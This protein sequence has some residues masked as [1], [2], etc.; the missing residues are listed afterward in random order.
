MNLF[1]C[2]SRLQQIINYI[3]AKH[4]FYKFDLILAWYYNVAQQ[5]QKHIGIKDFF[6]LCSMANRNHS[7]PEK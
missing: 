5:K 1:C 4:Y 2:L 6:M 3:N 7:V